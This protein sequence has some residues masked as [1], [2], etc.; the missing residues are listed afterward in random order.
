[1]FVSSFVFF[2]FKHHYWYN[3]Y[4]KTPHIVTVDTY[5]AL[6]FCCKNDI[7]VFVFF[8]NL[9]VVINRSFVIIKAKAYKGAY[10]IFSS[11]DE[12]FT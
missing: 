4:K 3:W 12:S 5:K 8:I 11:V 7:K 10:V 2:L 9:I 6:Y 1:M